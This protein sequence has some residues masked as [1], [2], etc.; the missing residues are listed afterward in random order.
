[1]QAIFHMPMMVPALE[2]QEVVHMHN[3]CTTF[4]QVVVPNKKKNTMLFRGCGYEV[5]GV[6]Y[7][8]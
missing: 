1:M 5:Y 8:P 2:K 4:E 7:L 3:F 6:G